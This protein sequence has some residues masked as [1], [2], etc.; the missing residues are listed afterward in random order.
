MVYPVLKQFVYLLV[1]LYNRTKEKVNDFFEK[2]KK[3]Q[4]NRSAPLVAFEA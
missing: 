3:K 4:I 1:L 2:L